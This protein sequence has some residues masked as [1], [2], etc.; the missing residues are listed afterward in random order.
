M[1]KLLN[2]YPAIEKPQNC[3]SVMDIIDIWCILSYI[4]HK[5]HRVHRLH[6]F[7]DAS[8]T[9][10]RPGQVAASS[11]FS[12]KD[13][14]DLRSSTF[15][16]SSS[17]NEA[18]AA[19]IFLKRHGFSPS[20]CHCCTGK[21]WTGLEWEVHDFHTKPYC[22]EIHMEVS[23]NRGTLFHSSILV[24]YVLLKPSII[25]CFLLSSKF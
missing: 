6:E 10:K 18:E 19:W 13:I 22:M 11:Y 3:Y 8:S 17:F 16:G 2:C 12:P 5:L 23:W 1:T 25:F 21:G 7:H 15:H 24:W 14:S 9:K 4:I 20:T